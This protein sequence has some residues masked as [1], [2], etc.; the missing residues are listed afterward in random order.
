MMVWIS[1]IF[2]FCS[3]VLTL[4]ISNPDNVENA[5]D[6]NFYVT[7]D[8]DLDSKLTSFE[9]KIKLVQKNSSSKAYHSSQTEYY[10]NRAICDISS[11]IR[12]NAKDE[13]IS[14]IS[15]HKD[16]QAKVFSQYYDNSLVLAKSICNNCLSVQNE[17]N[18]LEKVLKDLKLEFDLID[19]QE[20]LYRFIN[21]INYL[22]L[23]KVDLEKISN[24]IKALRHFDCE[25]KEKTEQAYQDIDS[26]LNSLVVLLQK[27]MQ[28]NNIGISMALLS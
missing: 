21:K 25:S 22:N 2:C 1:F 17:L 12:Q 3:A 6:L 10:I 7:N 20:E 18:Q 23:V 5:F 28:S 13:K 14:E 26:Y 15:L 19:P 11:I 8:A 27:K 9:N 16:G 4:R 24:F